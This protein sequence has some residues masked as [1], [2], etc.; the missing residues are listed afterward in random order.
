MSTPD[1][2]RSGL[3]A[4]ILLFCFFG[5]V[6]GVNGVIQSVYWDS[7]ILDCFLFSRKYADRI[8]VRS[9]A[10]PCFMTVMSCQSKACRLF[11]L[12]TSC[13]IG[14]MSKDLRSSL[15]SPEMFPT[16]K[17]SKAGAQVVFG[18]L[19]LGTPWFFH[20]F[21]AAKTLQCDFPQP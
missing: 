12:P 15:F 2:Q 14:E 1:V 10:C 4:W 5:A 7:Y 3:E 20:C 18:Y 9:I 16:I 11:L 8:G 21:F 6:L 13:G 19:N 17:E